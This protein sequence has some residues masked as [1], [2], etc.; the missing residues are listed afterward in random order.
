[1]NTILKLLKVLGAIANT[2]V[3]IITMLVVS[4]SGIDTG[5]AHLFSVDSIVFR[6]LDWVTGLSVFASI[7]AGWSLALKEK[8]PLLI[9][10]ICF[11]PYILIG[12]GLTI[13]HTQL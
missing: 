12:I 10:V 2:L 5:H 8:S 9:Y 1:M 6:V 3:M 13:L 7:P 11:A 4:L